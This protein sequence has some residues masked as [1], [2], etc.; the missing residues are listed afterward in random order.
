MLHCGERFLAPDKQGKALLLSHIIVLQGVAVAR[1]NMPL[2]LSEQ[3][4]GRHIERA[5]AL[6][7]ACF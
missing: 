2:G 1:I 7:L 4:G 3:W 6:S 5:V